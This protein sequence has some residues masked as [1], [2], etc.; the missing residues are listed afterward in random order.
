MDYNLCIDIGNTNIKSG[1]FLN[2]K[3]ET[4]LVAVEEL[5]K[6]ANNKT[7]KC[8]IS[9]VR[10][11]VPAEIEK[12]AGDATKNIILSHK[13]RMPVIIDYKT[14]ETLGMDRVA[15]A[16]GAK[17]HFPGQNCIVIDA[18]TCITSDFIDKENIY[19]GGIISPGIH[20]RIKAMHQFTG[21]LPLV[22]IKYNDD[23]LGKS[24]E[25]A[26][27][28]GALKGTIW[29]ISAFI[30]EINKKFGKSRVVFTGG[31]A[32]YFVNYFKTMIFADSNL[33]LVG[34][35]EILKNYEK[36]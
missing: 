24:T 14:P 33:I 5:E 36:N 26:L 13:T 28:N 1:F 18:G 11:S 8:I 30:K 6:A 16:I 35:N 17:K 29:E 12:I 27:Q 2:D 9:N 31:D 21:A 23:L 25:E 15:A 19:H 7:Y 32:K 20:M 4:T 3:L 22:N 10:K 34:L